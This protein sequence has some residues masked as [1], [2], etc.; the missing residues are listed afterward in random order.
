[1]LQSTVIHRHTG[2][3]EPD[4]MS[5]QLLKRVF[6]Y[7]TLKVGEKNHCLLQNP[8]NGIAKFLCKATTTI[9]LPLVVATKYNIPFLINKPTLGSYVTGEIFEVNS[10]M[11]S[12]L[13][14]LEDVGN[15]YD[16]T[17]MTFNL[18][19]NEGNIDANV[20]VLN[21]YPEGLLKLKMISEYKDTKDKPYVPLSDRTNGPPS[22]DLLWQEY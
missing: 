1:M 11:L 20:Y 19:I 22:K 13:D 21:K 15:Y 3:S 2:N 9:K 14:E 7:G 16:R 8:K 4:I 10:Q 12:I 6:L 5:Q 17:T 18:G